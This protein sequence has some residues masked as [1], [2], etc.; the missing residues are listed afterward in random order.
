MAKRSKI[1]NIN[2]YADCRQYLERASAGAVV[3]L[4]F[5]TK[6]EAIQWRARAYKY[7]YLLAEQETKKLGLDPETDLVSTRFDPLIIRVS[8]GPNGS[9]IATISFRN[10]PLKV[11]VVEP[12]GSEGRPIPLNTEPDPLEVAKRLLEEQGDD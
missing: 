6:K 5:E 9:G 10:A 1:R 8:D 3:R 2:A 12:E 7:R 4:T 11:E